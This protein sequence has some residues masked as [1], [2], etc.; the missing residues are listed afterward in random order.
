MTNSHIL[1]N[2]LLL[3]SALAF[4]LTCKAVSTF[5]LLPQTT[6]TA[7][8]TPTA[9]SPPSEGWIAFVNKNN[10]WLIH[11]DGSGLKQVTDNP[12]TTNNDADINDIR[13]K[14]SPDGQKLAFS[15]G[16]HLYV[17]DI[18]TFTSTLLVEDTEG[19]FDWSPTSKQIVYDTKVIG[20]RDNNG[21][22][23]I[24]IETG[25]KRQ[26]VKPS[27]DLLAT[28]GPQLS[29]EGSHLIF[30]WPS[31]E[32]SGY[33]VIDLNTGKY[34]NLPVQ[35]NSGGCEW[36]PNALLI[37]CTREIPNSNAPYGEEP[38][39]VVLLDQNAN[40]LREFPLDTTTNWN[41]WEVW[42]PD[43]KK[44]AIG[45][46]PNEQSQTKL[47]SLDTGDFNVFASGAPLDWS[48][49]ENW[50]LT[51][52]AE[53]SWNTP[54]HISVVNVNF[55]T[56]YLLSEGMLASWQPS[57]ESTEALPTSESNIF[58]TLPTSTP[59]ST[60]VPTSG[61]SITINDTPK[62]EFLQITAMGNAYE[63]GPLEKGAYAIGPNSKFLVYCT[64]SGIVYA[65]RIGD[66]NLTKIGSVKDLSAIVQGEAPQ[67]DFQF[68]GDNPYTVQIH[69]S[70]FNQNETLSIPSYITR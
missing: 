8:A 4:G 67:V 44:L 30:S 14:W 42:S 38:N 52:D 12:P 36:A 10:V 54:R 47:L 55:G 41:Y 40:V 13:I 23:L 16:G 51:W 1:K 3:L 27:A 48:P 60:Q 50:I 70:L 53:S 64:N 46:L 31:F 5:S 37:A 69:D 62:G 29:S 9:S 28:I 25:N 6:P 26:I 11:P 66:T 39:E 49:D 32:A 56:S 15:Q 43:G 68:F 21:M 61:V 45:Y 22:W 34:I 2:I 20:N 24:N 35:G 19:G 33:D 65:A 63:I 58:L 57:K 59:S 17:L 7:F 18:A